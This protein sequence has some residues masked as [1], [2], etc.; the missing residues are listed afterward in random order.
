MYSLPVMSAPNL[1]I[2]AEPWEGSALVYGTLAAR[3]SADV[4][5]GQ[6][7][8]VLT[9]TNNEATQVH[10]NQ[11]TVSFVGPPAVG[12][13]SIPADLMVGTL[14]T[15]R[16]VFETANNIILPVPAP[17]A[18]HIAL[19]CDGFTDAAAL[20]VPLVPYASPIAG[21]AY[22]FP[23][24]VTDL[25]RGEL[26]TGLS[27]AH[28]SGGGT[29]L[30]A[31]DLL[32]RRFDSVA[33]SWPTFIPGS[34]NTVNANYYIWGK[35]V[36]AMADGVVVQ[37][38]DGMPPNTPPGFPNPVPNPIE[39]NHFYLQHG[40]DLVLYAH[41]QAGTLNPS[42]IAGPN[43]DGT[44][45]AVTKGQVLGLAGNTGNSSEPHLHL[46]VNRTTVPWGGPLRPLPFNGIYVLDLSLV[47]STTPNSDSPWN[48]VI[49]QDLPNV[50]SAI[51]PGPLRLGKASLFGRFALLAWAWIIII[52]ALMF[53]PGGV[54]CIACGPTLT[55]VLG[56]VSIVLGSVGLIGSVMA[57]RASA[58]AK[59]SLPEIDAKGNLH[60]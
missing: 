27:A 12:S 52:G 33:K 26:W 35:P 25:N 55:N 43:S 9:I 7:S 3:T 15:K 19:S 46:H 37:F 23:A 1:T 30:F 5:A 17:G 47:P 22:E 44:G 28:S 6:L 58:P 51:W 10:L 4:A 54:E 59:A 34:D 60:G 50:L 53:T 57:G 32:V 31:Y 39:G 42:L 56:V 41:L 8:L 11:V 13:S 36:L 14:E 38:H 49:A 21:G 20:D 2:S 24:S 29:Q 45:A 18:V 40:P 16:W 48:H